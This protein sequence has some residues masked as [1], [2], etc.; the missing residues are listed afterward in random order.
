MHCP[1]KK[2]IRKCNK[3]TESNC[4]FFSSLISWNES[5]KWW[6][7]TKTKGSHLFHSSPP[8]S[9]VGW[10]FGS[11]SRAFTKHG[12]QLHWKSIIS[13]VLRCL[14]DPRTCSCLASVRPVNQ[15]HFTALH[16]LSNGTRHPNYLSNI[17]IMHNQQHGGS[18]SR[19]VSRKETERTFKSLVIW[20][21]P[22]ID[23]KIWAKSWLTWPLF[24]W[25]KRWTP[26]ETSH[27]CHP[28]FF[29]FCWGGHFQK[30]SLWF[31]PNWKILYSQIGPFPQRKFKN[32][33]VATTLKRKPDRLP[34]SDISWGKNLRTAKPPPGT[35]DPPVSMMLKQ[36]LDTTSSRFPKLQGVS[37]LIKLGGGYRIHTLSETNSSH[38]KIGRT[39]IGK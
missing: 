26:P 1:T 3:K 25:V 16:G 24:G 6:I 4:S 29:P 30:S 33:W 7:F 11:V 21:V 38:L 36:I 35:L 19:E 9:K 17:R 31:Q 22:S 20:N 18:T 8:F 32:I 28:V 23:G 2:N 27:A 15:D 39:P 34:R 37:L 13:R 14:M 5:K 10:S 12:P